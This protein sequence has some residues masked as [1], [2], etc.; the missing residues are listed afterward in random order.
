MGPPLLPKAPPPAGRCVSGATDGE[1][2]GTRKRLPRGRS[3][4]PG[5]L[6]RHLYG[7]RIPVSPCLA[8]EQPPCAPRSYSDADA[9]G[10]LWAS[11]LSLVPVPNPAISQ[12]DKKRLPFLA[13]PIVGGGG[14][15][16]SCMQLLYL[17]NEILAS[18]GCCQPR[19]SQGSW[20]HLSKVGFISEYACISPFCNGEAH[21][22]RNMSLRVFLAHCKL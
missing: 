5:R 12:C 16:G 11:I 18:S 8:G 1:C 4:Q 7:N 14:R 9:S 22:H 10:F 15:P 2:L 3:P 13:D 6:P 19:N 17:L 21:L 20:L